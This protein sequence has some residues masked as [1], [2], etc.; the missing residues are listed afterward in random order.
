MRTGTPCPLPRLRSH[1]AHPCRRPL[2]PDSFRDLSGALHVRKYHDAG[3]V[4]GA[5]A[6]AALVATPCRAEPEP[7]PLG[8]AGR[9]FLEAHCFEC[10][11]SEAK[12]AGLD[13]STL[14][15]DLGAP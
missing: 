7:E 2:L 14:G 1:P 4:L 3:W 9:A 6:I 8:P 15:L 5:L 12:K 11:D 10:H 13:L